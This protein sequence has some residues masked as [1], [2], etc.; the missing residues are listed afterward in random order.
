MPVSLS[1]SLER[2][3]PRTCTALFYRTTGDWIDAVSAWLRA[4]LARGEKCLL[5]GKPAFV[6]EIFSSL[7][8]RSV[9]VGNA[10]ASGALLPLLSADP[11]T[12]SSALIS[13]I[14][15][16]CDLAAVERFSGIR[17]CIDITPPGKKDARGGESAMER[18]S[19]LRSFVASRDLRALFLIPQKAF[20]PA[21][22]MGLLRA[23]PYVIRK[24]SLLENFYHEPPGPSGTQDPSR[25]FEQSL[26]R[27]AE[28]HDQVARIRR[29]AVRLQRLRDIT[30]SMLAHP[31]AVSDP[32][33]AV[34]EGVT[35]LGYRMCWLGMARA[36]GTVEPVAISGNIRG[37]LEHVTVRW[38][39][40]PLGRGPTGTAI[41]TGMPDVVSDVRR[42]PRIS[43]WKGEAL[44]RGLFSVAAIPLRED[45]KVAGALTVYATAPNAFDPEAVEEL[46]A[47]ALQAS[48]ALGRARDYRELSLSEARMRR[49]FDQIPAACFTYDRD[50]VIRSWNMRC[51]KLYGYSPKEAVGKRLGDLVI[52]PA[53]A[54][55]ASD[56]VSRVFAGESISRLEWELQ[57][58]AGES[59]WALTSMYPFRGERGAVEL[60]IGVSVDIT[61]RVRFEHDRERT[62]METARTQKM[63]AMGSLAGGIAHEFNDVLESIIGHCSLLLSKE[64]RAPSAETI[65]GIQASAERAADLTAKLLGFA[66]GGKIRVRK[67]SLNEVAEHVLSAVSRSLPPS[68]RLE[69]HLD[70]KLRAVAGDR[71]QLDQALMNLCINARDALPH[72][73]VLTVTTGNATLTA[74]EARKY[75]VAEPGGYVFVEVR[76]TGV[77]MT[78]EVLKHIFDPFYTTN[79]DKGRA[80]MGLSM[81]YGVVKNHSGGI[82]VE[83]APGEGSLFRFYLPAI[84]RLVVR[85]CEPDPDPYPKGTET[86]LVVDDEPALREMAESM[87]QALGYRTFAAEDGEAACRLFR[88]RSGEIDLVLLDIVMPKMGGPG[89]YRALREMKPGIPVLLSSGYSVEEVVQEILAE[90]A[91]GFLPKPYG[92]S[93][94]A[95][96]VRKAISSAVVS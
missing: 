49:L 91:N 28:R 41:R 80:G 92:L 69:G 94:I 38:D 16:Q 83:S 55:E 17:L 43:P 6:E 44:A 95:R 40:T 78:R 30:A 35:A 11:G 53:R 77:G 48:L 85:E 21:S 4:G 51:R 82:H 24:G 65:R 33:L 57:E 90:G 29:Q 23:H 18:A 32:F 59:R 36:D 45:G 26:S 56:V 60:G 8:S 58:R 67:M 74:A 87:L 15:E 89:A 88:E 31:S 72:G 20:P 19:A 76:D 1:E 10:L 7:Q 12:G 46:T 70:P 61:E 68:I 62:R 63:E 3:D 86:V 39:D 47:F 93:Q 96:A 52:L 37:Y 42:M 64:P 13:R 66:R 79:R 34:A 2:V 75:Y 73:G 22:L 84:D 81:V 14:K 54:Q 50:G 5:H 71:A 27:L 25:E 9:D